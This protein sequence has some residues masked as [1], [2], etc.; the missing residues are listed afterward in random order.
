[1]VTLFSAQVPMGGIIN[2]GRNE[3][4]TFRD[5]FNMMQGKVDNIVQTQATGSSHQSRK[6][7]ILESKAIAGI[8]TLGSDK[9]SFRSWNDKLINVLSQARPGCRCMLK[10]MA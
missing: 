5:S 6:W 1:M 4:H 9:T 3:I 8:K 7:G 2:A 10:A